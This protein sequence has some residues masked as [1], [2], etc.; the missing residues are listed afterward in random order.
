MPAVPRAHRHQDERRVPQRPARLLQVPA[1][2][3]PACLPRH[4]DGLPGPPARHGAEAPA[5]SAAGAR[6]GVH[7]VSTSCMAD[8]LCFAVL[9]VKKCTCKHSIRNWLRCTQCPPDVYKTCIVLLTPSFFIQ[10]RLETRKGSC[11]DACKLL[12][13]ASNAPQN[14]HKSKCNNLKR[15]PVPAS[16]LSCP[17]NPEA[18]HTSLATYSSRHH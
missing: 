11:M 4:R 2:G 15:Q 13:A 3:R 17:G 7:A 12:P 9:L 1:Q 18:S 16:M 5:C 10:N 6:Q 8:V 14:M